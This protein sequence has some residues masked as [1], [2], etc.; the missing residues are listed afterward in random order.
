M[1]IHPGVYVP[2]G[3]V[4]IDGITEIGTG[5]VLS[6]FISIGLVADVFQGPII[7]R[8]ARIG[9]GARVLGPIDIGEGAVVGA[10]A[11][12]VRDVPA[13]AT[14][15]GVPARVVSQEPSPAT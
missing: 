9:T 13:G 7:G 2:H 15:V 1:V 10:N 3:Q 14:V 12:V 6:P 8:R 4:V 11:V 5:A